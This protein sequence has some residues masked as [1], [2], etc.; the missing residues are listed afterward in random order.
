M[1]LK[2][3]T[4]EELDSKPPIRS[5]KGVAALGFSKAKELPKKK[6]QST[7]TA[8][9]IEVAILYLLKY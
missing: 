2:T 9:L 1:P 6:K 3:A 7:V 5:P 8:N 4:S